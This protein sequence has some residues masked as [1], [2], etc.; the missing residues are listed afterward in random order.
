MTEKELLDFLGVA[1]PD[2]PLN[3]H[4]PALQMPSGT[5]YPPMPSPLIW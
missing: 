3:L 2:N 4:D 5:G 1:S